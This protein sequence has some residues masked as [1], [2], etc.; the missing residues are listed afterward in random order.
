MTFR[1]L[2]DRI[3]NSSY[4]GSPNGSAAKIINANDKERCNNDI[5]L[6]SSISED[7]CNRRRAES[8]TGFD[9]RIKVATEIEVDVC[10]INKPQSTMLK[11]QPWSESGPR[12]HV[13]Q[14]LPYDCIKD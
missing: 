2:L 6:Q 8:D 3:G 11:S 10:G 5:P 4:R 13:V 9:S 7:N 14:K 12:T 1:P